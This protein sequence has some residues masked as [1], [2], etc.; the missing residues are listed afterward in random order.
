MPRLSSRSRHLRF[1]APANA[2]SATAGRLNEFAF[3]RSSFKMIPVT[4]IQFTI[5]VLLVEVGE[6]L[7]SFGANTLLPVDRSEPDGGHVSA[8]D[9]VEC[10]QE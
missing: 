4:G 2:G 9:T 1:T 6:D 7:K 3:T 10:W 5:Q 8:L